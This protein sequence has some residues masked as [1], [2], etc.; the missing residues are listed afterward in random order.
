MIDNLLIP[1]DGSEPANRAI[2]FTIRLL[3]NTS[4]QVTLLYVVE[5]PVYSVFW[6]D[7]LVAPEVFLPPPEEMHKELD[8]KAEEMLK[9]SLKPL[10]EAGIEAKPKVRFGN[11]PSEIL[12]EAE[13]GGYD[14]IAMGSHGRGILGNFLLGSVSNRIVHH[15]KCPVVIV[16][17]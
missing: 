17:Q 11:P 4:C 5:E 16:R 12:F 10:R 7:G 8:R 15:A 2:D 3:V 1:T 13:E 6:A 9:D 14:M